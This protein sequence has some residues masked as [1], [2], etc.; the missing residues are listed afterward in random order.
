MQRLANSRRLGYVLY[1]AV[2]R[3]PFRR[4]GHSSAHGCQRALGAHRRHDRDQRRDCRT[5]QASCWKGLGVRRRRHWRP[6]SRRRSS[7]RPPS[8]RLPLVQV[9]LHVRRVHHGR[10]LLPLQR[11][12]THR[13]G[14]PRVLP[15]V[16]LHLRHVGHARRVR[17]RHGI[18]LVLLLLSV[19]LSLGL[20]LGLSLSVSLSGLRLHGLRLRSLSGLRLRLRRLSGLHLRLRLHLR[21]SL[22]LCMG[23]CL[24]MSL[25][26]R[27]ATRLMRPG[28]CCLHHRRHRTRRRRRL[29]RNRRRHCGRSRPLSRPSRHRSSRRHCRR[30]KRR[31]RHVRDL[32]RRRDAFHSLDQQSLD[33]FGRRRR[34]RF[35]ACRRR[36]CRCRQ[37]SVGHRRHHRRC[38]G[39]RRRF[40]WRR[41]ARLHSRRHNAAGAV[42]ASISRCRSL[43]GRLGWHV[44]GGRLGNSRGNQ[45][46]GS[47]RRRR[48]R[49]RTLPRRRCKR[50][51]G[52]QRR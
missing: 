7:S 49:R 52:V 31:R 4:R 14:V 27:P 36:R 3:P 43:L 16:L 42:A 38:C 48:R 25:L 28:I 5:R 40:A 30:R 20:G 46:R 50:C 32:R 15:L 10:M 17:H 1:S 47:R 24:Y 13:H 6:H 2:V 39:Q 18:M 33:L 11:R 19:R 26:A 9:D 45:S 41:R 21:L 29:A 37:R 51:H 22:R 34:R 8:V 12:L 23:L 44:G 35:A